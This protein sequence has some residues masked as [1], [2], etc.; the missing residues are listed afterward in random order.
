MSS[1]SNEETSTD[2]DYRVLLHLLLY[3]LLNDE[4]AEDARAAVAAD[5]DVAKFY[6][7]ALANREI[8]KRAARRDDLSLKTNDATTRSIPVEPTR[9]ETSSSAPAFGNEGVVGDGESAISC[10]NAEV[11]GNVDFLENSDSSESVPASPQP[12][13]NRKRSKT[14]SNSQPLTANEIQKTGRNKFFQRG[15]RTLRERLQKALR[16]LLRTSLLTRVLVAL[17]LLFVLTA[18]LALLLQSRQLRHLLRDEFRVQATL[19]NALVRDESQQIIVCTSDINGKPKRT[20]VRFCFSDPKTHDF[21]IAHT[22]I[23]SIDG[24]ASYDLPDLTDFPEEVCLSVSAGSDEVEAFQTFLHVRDSRVKK[25]QTQRSWPRP[26]TTNDLVPEVSPLWTNAFNSV[27]NDLAPEERRGDVSEE[28]ST[29]S[30]PPG[31]LSDVSD[32]SDQTE[33]AIEEESNGT[34]DETFVLYLFPETGSF[35]SNYENRVVALC[36][37]S[38]GRPQKGLRFFLKGENAQ[39]PIVFDTDSFGT[40][41]LDWNFVKNASYLLGQIS[42]ENEELTNAEGETLE[43]DELSP[44]LTRDISHPEVN[45]ADSYISVCFNPS[46]FKSSASFVPLSKEPSAYFTVKKRTLH[47]DEPLCFTVKADDKVPLVMVLEKSGVIVGERLLSAR[48]GKKHFEIKVPENLSGL[49]NVSLYSYASPT[50]FEKI[51]E[52]TFF[53]RYSADSTVF[54]ATIE[55]E[56]DG[57]DQGGKDGDSGT[58]I[59]RTSNQNLEKSRSKQRKW[60]ELPMTLETVWFPDYSSAVASLETDDF[61]ASLEDENLEKILATTRAANNFNPPVMLDNLSN[62][63]MR[64]RDKLARYRDNEAN[65]SLWIVRLGFW[66]CVII[67]VVAVYLAIFNVFTPLKGAGVLICAALCASFLWGGQKLLSQSFEAT[68]DIVSLIDDEREGQVAGAMRKDSPATPESLQDSAPDL[69]ENVR[70]TSLSVSRKIALGTWKASLG[71]LFKTD[72]TLSPGVVLII[73]DDGR[74]RSWKIIPLEQPD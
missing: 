44:E 14:G 4:D 5:S 74:S 40:A 13:K 47:F 25:G 49:F 28:T 7:E 23:G 30:N 51:G 36:L 11:I 24:Y 15:K 21:I 22:E 8:I 59:V 35:A 33:D 55:N 27:M 58:L 10:E 38:E 63:K 65:A 60:N 43:V 42:D 9:F 68:T 3:G 57:S 17:L 39:K 31:S 69:V 19:P 45:A 6:D 48:N 20:P 41:V 73:L 29:N 56:I 54:S 71:E 34:T 1:K 16:A 52:S 61:Y 26:F 32:P 66:G 2:R 62:L 53:R 67:V 50:R 18:S 70:S 72:Q 64:I 12:K 46:D 37:D